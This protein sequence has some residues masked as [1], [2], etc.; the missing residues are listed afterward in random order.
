MLIFQTH[1]A[2]FVAPAKT[3]LLT[4]VLKPSAQMVRSP[5][6]GQC[7]AMMALLQLVSGLWSLVWSGLVSGP[8]SL[9]S[10][11]SL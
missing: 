9:V 4:M 8:W 10:E 6:Y 7:V 5:H 1:C 11:V 2:A 3:I